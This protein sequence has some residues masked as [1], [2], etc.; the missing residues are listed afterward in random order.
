MNDQ[1]ELRSEPGAPADI[2]DHQHD[3]QHLRDSK[4]N[5]ATDL[6][7]ILITLIILRRPLLMVLAAEQ[8]W[9]L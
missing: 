9:L 6:F 3:D 8:A 4:T 7:K 5:L 2:V 1:Y